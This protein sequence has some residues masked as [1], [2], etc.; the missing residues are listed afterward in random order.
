MVCRTVPSL[1]IAILAGCS[2]G[3]EPPAPA[4]P[5]SGSGSLHRPSGQDRPADGAALV[6]TVAGISR[7]SGRYWNG[8]TILLPPAHKVTVRF[9]GA[10][11]ALRISDRRLWTGSGG[12]LG[13]AVEDRQ[14]L[15]TPQLPGQ[16]FAL[17]QGPGK[18]T[19]GFRVHILHEAEMTRNR[20]LGTTRLKVGGS[21]IG[22][23]PNPRTARS[24]RVRMHARFFKP[25]RYWMRITAGNQQQQL[26]P[27]VQMGQMVGFI[28]EKDK[29]RPKRRHSSW[30]PPNRE[31][32]Y[33]LELLTRELLRKKVKVSRLAVNSAFRAP[34]YNRRIGGS[35]YS[36]HIYGDAA[37]VM[38]DEDGDEVCDDITGDGRADHRD[39]L[40]IGQAIRKLQLSGAIRPGGIGVYGFIGKDSARSYS[41]FDC[42]G[43]VTRWGS[44]YRGRRKLPLEWWPEEEYR[45]DQEPPP[46]FRSPPP[47]KPSAKARGK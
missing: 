27:H 24:W 32:V 17:K 16:S 22:T 39:G 18:E 14:Q 12:S 44:H 35:S 8:D 20:K 10:A 1:L 4:K 37:D 36:R 38:V 33:S 19:L 41:H 2:S 30:F 28:T 11:A 9:L 7:L 42:R 13:E 40:V 26:A 46:E 34:F 23:Y 43:Y 5:P 29:T 15:F 25:P 47:K 45:E 6:V 31:L 21:I 3:A